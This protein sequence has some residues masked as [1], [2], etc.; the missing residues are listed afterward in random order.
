M[1]I[2]RNADLLMD[3]RISLTE[4]LT[5]FQKPIHHLDGRMVS[6]TAATITITAPPPIPP[7]AAFPV[8]MISTSMVMVPW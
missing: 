1:V 2:A 4:A 7:P 6:G 8:T 3:M 5:G